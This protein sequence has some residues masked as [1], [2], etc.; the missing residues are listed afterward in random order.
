MDSEKAFRYQM[1]IKGGTDIDGAR[2]D[3]YVEGAEQE[4]LWA[5]VEADPDAYSQPVRETSGS[6]FNA[7]IYAMVLK[8][9]A[10]YKTMR[11]AEALE[12]AAFAS[13][14]EAAETDVKQAAE[15]EPRED[16]T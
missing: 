6:A 2:E 3:G 7:E 16:A 11:E 14:S 8:L 4:A 12:K 9:Q 1:L 15:D 5:I 10:E 13:R